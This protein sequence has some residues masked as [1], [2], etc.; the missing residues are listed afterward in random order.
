MKKIIMAT[1]LLGGTLMLDAQDVLSSWN[2]GENKRS[3]IDF[4][5]SVSDKTSPDYVI[6]KDRIAV[7]DNDGTLS[8]LYIFNLCLQSIASKRKPR[9]IQNGDTK[10][11]SNQF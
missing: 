7:F 10:S 2:N 8:N 6:P 9:I 11:H 3:I 1:V 4:V 5:H